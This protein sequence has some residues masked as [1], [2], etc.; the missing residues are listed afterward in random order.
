MPIRMS[1]TPARR[2]DDAKRS[3]TRLRMSNP[4]IGR[5]HLRSSGQGSPS[6]SCETA[7][8]DHVE[9]LDRTALL[10]VHHE[11]ERVSVAWDSVVSDE[12]H[13]VACRRLLERSGRRRLLEPLE[14][15]GI[16]R[17]LAMTPCHPRPMPSRDRATR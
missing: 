15:E 12:G 10:A 5:A 2:T 14:L 9:S 8:R 7:E 6:A 11:A 1:Y 17:A 3:A 13:A 16:T 4:I